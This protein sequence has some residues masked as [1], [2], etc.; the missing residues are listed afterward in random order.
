MVEALDVVDKGEQPGSAQARHAAGGGAG[1]DGR[2][3][4]GRRGGRGGGPGK[5][6]GRGRRKRHWGLRGQRR[7]KGKGRGRRWGRG[8]GRRGGRGSS[9]RRR[10]P[11]HD[12]HDLGLREIHRHAGRTRFTIE[13]AE[14]VHQGG[15]ISRDEHHVVRVHQQGDEGGVE[16]RVGMQRLRGGGVHQVVFHVV[17]DRDAEVGAPGQ[18]LANDGVDVDVEQEGHDDTPLPDAG[19]D[20]E[21][22]GRDAVQTHSGGAPSVEV[23]EESR[24]RQSYFIII[25]IKRAKE[26]VHPMHPRQS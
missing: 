22:G 14:G 2:G 8:R 26:S 5:G 6:R 21:G 7:G 17:L 12:R 4:A 23:P 1:G 10:R 3:G 25:I 9:G 18:H 19:G 24:R 11:R 13:G 20:S 16:R 15:A